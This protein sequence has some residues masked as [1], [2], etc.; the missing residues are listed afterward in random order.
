MG[1]IGLEG[2][3]GLTWPVRELSWNV[4]RSLLL[5]AKGDRPTEKGVEE[6]SFLPVSRHQAIFTVQKRSLVDLQNGLFPVTLC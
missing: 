3:I 5:E 2:S 1:A 6:V 4:K